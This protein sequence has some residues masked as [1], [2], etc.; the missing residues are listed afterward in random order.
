MKSPGGKACAICDRFVDT[1][2][3]LLMIVFDI[4]N[5]DCR[6]GL[7]R[8]NLYNQPE[9]TVKSH[10]M[11]VLSITVKLLKVKRFERIKRLDVLGVANHL[12]PHAKRSHNRI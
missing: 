8:L 10:R 12:H 5:G 4:N 7:R 2:A 3:R 9:L 11:L 1:Y 6:F